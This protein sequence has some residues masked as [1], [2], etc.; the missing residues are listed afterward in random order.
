[1]PIARVP[2]FPHA[3]PRGRWAPS[4]VVRSA[5]LNHIAQA[6]IALVLVALPLAF[7][8][9]SDEGMRIIAVVMV[10]IVG[11]FLLLLCVAAF[12][13]CAT[14]AMRRLLHIDAAS[15]A[16]LTETATVTALK[17]LPICKWEKDAEPV[18]CALCLEQLRVDDVI[19]NLPCSHKFHKECIDRWFTSS[20]FL[21]DLTMHTGHTLSQFFNALCLRA[22]DT[23]ATGAMENRSRFCP[24]CKA[25]PLCTR[26][27]TNV[28]GCQVAAVSDI[29][30]PP[31]TSEDAMQT[32]IESSTHSGD[33]VTLATQPQTQGGN[34]R[35]AEPES[36]LTAD[37][38]R[39]GG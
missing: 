20:A 37:A 31:M 11:T 3:L 7:T 28:K 12:D 9:S 1:M 30:A 17:S 35:P 24:M 34:E 36:V 38:P 4:R 25:N 16:E 10:G 26:A 32:A 18:E 2:H 6:A 8:G 29:E 21:P 14:R 22:V 19:R 39:D 33:S 15:D 23:S 5:R 13:R 27:E